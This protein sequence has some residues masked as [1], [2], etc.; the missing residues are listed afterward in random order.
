MCS[1]YER[2]VY[3]YI[4]TG[5]AF[6]DT[7]WTREKRLGISINVYDRIERSALP[8]FKVSMETSLNTCKLNI[9]FFRG[10]FIV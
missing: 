5:S 9:P 7:N 8:A 3:K 4:G 2:G 10:D 6:A 1:Y